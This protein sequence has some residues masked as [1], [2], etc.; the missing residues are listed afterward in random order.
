MKMKTEVGKLE[1]KMEYKF[2]REYNIY[3]YNIIMNF[4]CF[5][6]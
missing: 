1:R 4:F 6:N 5:S 3:I 2:K